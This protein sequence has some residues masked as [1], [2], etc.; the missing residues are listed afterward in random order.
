M[1]AKTKKLV[2][3]G[4]GEFGEIAYEY[5]TYDSEYQVVAFAV[6]SKYKDKEIM[7]GLPVIAF[8]EIQKEYP[9]EEY[10]VFVAITYVQ[11][12]RPRRRLYN[13]CKEL[14]YHCASYISSRA[15]VW[16]N[17]QVGE[18]TFIFEN[19]TLQHFVTVGNN[20]VLWSG[21]HVG[22][23]TVIEDDVWI[24]SHDCISG[25]CRIGRGS[26]IGVNATLG[27][28]VELAEDTVFG[29][30]SLTVKNLVEKGCVYIGS[31]AKKLSKTAYEQFGI[32]C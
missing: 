6:E 30:G 13:R 2:I 21:N 18:N 8:E 24:T 9:P 5:F 27:D 20:V 12:N 16:H 4:A 28:N 25:F 3:I 10:D 14:G 26:F 22:H 32:C 11:L 1:E 31:P 23:R 19:N 7:Y 17:V 29:A 15:F